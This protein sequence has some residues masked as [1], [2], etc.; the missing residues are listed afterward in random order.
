MKGVIA[1][2]SLMHTQQGSRVIVVTAKSARNDDYR[3]TCGTR[4]AQICEARLCEN[5]NILRSGGI[6][7]R[8]DSLNQDHRILY[9]LT[10]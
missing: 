8:Q 6:V 3:S 1:D 7:E 2:L 4:S 9:A 5:N 10:Q